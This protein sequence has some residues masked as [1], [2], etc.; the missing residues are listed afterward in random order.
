MLCLQ[1]PTI[2]L[3]AELPSL[4]AR[5]ERSQEPRLPEGGWPWPDTAVAVA[6]PPLASGEAGASPVEAAI[7]G[8]IGS[9][10]QQN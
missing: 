5:E 10:R 3:P 8:Q 6:G 1:V 9:P 7:G 2:R 4:G